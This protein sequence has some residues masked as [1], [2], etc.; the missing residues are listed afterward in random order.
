MNMKRTLFC[1]VASAA[2]GLPTFGFWSKPLLQPS[3]GEPT[4]QEKRIRDGK[5]AFEYATVF[6]GEEGLT[7]ITV[8]GWFRYAMDGTEDGGH[9]DLAISVLASNRRARAGL[10]GGEK[11][12]NLCSTNWWD[13]TENLPLGEDGTWAERCLPSSYDKPGVGISEDFRYGC[14]AVNVATDTPLTLDVAGYEVA[15]PVT[16]FWAFNA[17]ARS[18]S[19]TVSITAGSASAKVRFGIAENPLVQFVGTQMINIGDGM[20]MN[21]GISSGEW[22]LFVAKIGIEGGTNMAVNIFGY[23]VTNRLDGASSVSQPMW[24]PTRAF[25]RDA[26]IRV[27]VFGMVGLDGRTVKSWGFRAYGDSIPETLIER[28][29]DQDAEE[30][31]RIGLI[32]GGE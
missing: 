8:M 16:N 3:Y 30:M 12:T 18:E 6:V 4:L 26:R 21:N 14:Y 28:M 15:V 11:L 13:G 31:K 22:R 24:K 25:E 23:G 17:P 20:E 1:L 32:S 19:Q 27:L 9:K 29:R 10:E 7:N 5:D 2:F